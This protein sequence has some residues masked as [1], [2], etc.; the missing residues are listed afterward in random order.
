MNFIGGAFIIFTVFLPKL[1]F[2]TSYGEIFK[3]INVYSKNNTHTIAD[4]VLFQTSIG[5]LSFCVLFL[6]IGIIFIAIDCIMNK[7]TIKTDIIKN[8]LHWKKT[9]KLDELNT[10]IAKELEEANETIQ[11]LKQRISYLEQ[12]EK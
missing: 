1:V 3:I 9:Y 11:D 10:K 4:T 5:I 6:A 12:K 7:Q 2:G 8:K